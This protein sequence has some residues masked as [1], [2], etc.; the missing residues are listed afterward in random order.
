[1]NGHL[2]PVVQQ[3]LQHQLHGI[4]GSRAIRG[5]N[6]VVTLSRQP[7]RAGDLVILHIV[8]GHQTIAYSDVR[9]R[10]A[11][12]VRFSANCEY[13]A[14]A[15]RLELKRGIELRRLRQQAAG[16]H[17]N[18]PCYFKFHI[19]KSSWQWELV[20]RDPLS[21]ISDYPFR[22]IVRRIAPR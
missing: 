12:G 9:V 13:P 18:D 6:D 20:P 17:E 14:P 21:R 5:C 22:G 11:L 7:R 19:H 16:K 8:S 10:D 3:F 4:V 15:L 2:K 1:M